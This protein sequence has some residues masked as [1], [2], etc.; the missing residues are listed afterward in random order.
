MIGVVVVAV[1][2]FKATVSPLSNVIG[3]SQHFFFWKYLS[4]FLFTVLTNLSGFASSA[5]VI[6]YP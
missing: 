6:H 1:V 4:Q 5:M 2:A 3:C